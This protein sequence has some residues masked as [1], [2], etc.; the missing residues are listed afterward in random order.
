MENSKEL[1]K[2]QKKSLKMPFLIVVYMH[3]FSLFLFFVLFFFFLL[4]SFVIWIFFM[5]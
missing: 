3:D 2:K 5:S 1:K 4:R